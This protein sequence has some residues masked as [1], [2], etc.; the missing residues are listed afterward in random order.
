LPKKDKKILWLVKILLGFCLVM[1]LFVFS[2]L[3]FPYATSKAFAFRILVEIAAVFYFYLA[4]KY[5]HRFFFS[6]FYHFSPEPESSVSKSGCRN[7]LAP[8]LWRIGKSG[9]KISVAVLI[10]LLLWFLSTLLSTDFSLS[11]WGDLERMSGFWG[12]AHFAVFFLMLVAVF[13]DGKEWRTLL[14]ISV[15]VGSAV[16]LLAIVQRFVSLGSLLPQAERVYGTIGNAAFLAG[17]LIFNIFFAGY[18]AILSLRVTPSFEKGGVTKK[19]RFNFREIASSF[20]QGRISSNSKMPFFIYCLL[21][22]INCLALFFTGTRGAL[23]GLLAGTI[24]LLFTFSFFHVSKNFRRYSF[25]LLI[26]IL[27]LV[28]AVF[29]FKQNN[30]IQNNFILQRLSNISLKETTAQ[31]RLILWQSAWVSWQQFPIL[32]WGPEN[33]GVAINKNFDPRL[34]PYESWYDRAHNFIF[35]YGVTIG[36]LGLL[37]YLGIFAAAGWFL[38]KNIKQDFYFSAIFISLLTAYLVQ[39][40]FVFD[41]FTSY[42]MLFFVLGL[43]ANSLLRATV[44]ERSNL[45]AGEM[46][47][48]LSRRLAFC[49]DCLNS[50][51]KFF[52]AIVILA[53]IF[54][55]YFLNIKPLQASYFGNRIL[56]LPAQELQG[57]ESFLSRVIFLKTLGSEEIIYQVTIDYLSKANSFPQLTQ[58]EEFYK[59]ASAALAEN[60]KR[61]PL[62]V[63]NYIALGWLDLYFS[64]RHLERINS[65]IERARQAQEI[66]PYKKEVLLLLVAGY[67]VSN[68]SDKSLEV[69]E[70]TEEINEILGAQVRQYW[71]SLNRN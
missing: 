68:Q 37:G 44:E 43:I 21:L 7:L 4:L 9:M 8:K 69:L 13:K 60:I 70:K 28:G 17:Y 40:L 27:V 30:F 47:K 38:V 51:K 18:L 67:F 50:Y 29:I 58:N 65:A 59:L 20:C 71:E 56:S 52:L 12:L 22:A 46:S 42:L 61:S 55:V 45:M 19:S 2:G 34:A 36:W 63:K 26:F 39:N 11:F 54:S 10:F 25:V 66:S 1:P 6:L 24:F 3:L 32:G 23:L 5:P 53:V 33:F 16:A 49:S 48:G 14:K 64:D 15:A 41:T 57:A 31:N 62:Q 35:D